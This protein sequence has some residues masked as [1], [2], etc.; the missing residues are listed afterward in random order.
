MTFP[1]TNGTFGTRQ[2]YAA[3]L[4]QRYKPSLIDLGFGIIVIS[5]KD[6]IGLICIDSCVSTFLETQDHS[7]HPTQSADP[8]SPIEQPLPIDYRSL[9]HLDR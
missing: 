2:A 6:L 8:D 5:T 9:E 4:D 3:E 1:L 7:F